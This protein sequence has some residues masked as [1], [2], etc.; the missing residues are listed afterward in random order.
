MLSH[1]DLVLLRP[2]VRSL[3]GYVARRARHVPLAELEQIAWL[4]ALQHAP[5]FE[6][7]SDQEICEA[8]KISAAQLATHRAKCSVLMSDRD[9][10]ER[11]APADPE[12]QLLAREM[13]AKVR[14]AIR[15]LPKRLRLLIYLRFYRD[16]T[17]EN[18]SHDFNVSQSR[19]SQLYHDA[20]KALR[21]ELKG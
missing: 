15:R 4:T 11:T 2:C 12:D 17:H 20:L 18:I 9:P 19:T 14:R 8:L 3:V 21:R 6:G 5:Q 1:D 10:F 16:Q 7:A 13:T